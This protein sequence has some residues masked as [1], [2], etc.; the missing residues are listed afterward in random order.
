MICH[1]YDSSGEHVNSI[2]V[3]DEEFAKSYSEENGWTYELEPEPLPP[4][5]EVKLDET[6]EAMLDQI[7]YLEE[8]IVDLEMRLTE[9]EGQNGQS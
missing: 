2:I 3:A 7:A 4:P 8:T 5:Q 9:L 1:L 6:M